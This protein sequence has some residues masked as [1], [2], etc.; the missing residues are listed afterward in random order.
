MANFG[1]LFWAALVLC[2]AVTF[3]SSDYYK[4]IVLKGGSSGGGG[5]D[6]SL[7]DEVKKVHAGLL[8]RYLFVYLTATLSDWLQGPYVY[9]LYSDYGFQ[10]HEIAQLFVAGF[11]SSMIF[12]SFVGGMADWGG[13]R[14]FV[15]LFA[16]VY[17]ASCITKHFKDYGVLMLGR[18]LGGVSTSLLFSIFEAWLIRAHA[19]ADLPKSC[20][21]KS[22]SWA[23]FG[24]SCVAITAG[25]VANNIAHAGPMTPVTDLIYKGGY[26][27]PFDLALVALVCCAVGAAVLWEENYGEESSGDQELTNGKGGRGKWYDG[28]KNAFTTTIRNREILLCGFISSFFEG[29][30]YIFVFMWT[31]LLRS[32]LEDPNG[33]LPF[34]LIFATF[35]VCCMT[36]SS[37]FS[38]LVEKYPV[39]KLAVGIFMVASVAMAIVAMEIN[40]TM[41]FLGMNIFEMTVGMYFPVMGTMKGGI[42]PEDK[43]AAIY[44]LYRIPLNFIVLFSL[45]TDLTPR[46]SFMLNATMLATATVLQAMLTKRRLETTGRQDTKSTDDVEQAIPLV[47]NKEESDH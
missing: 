28:L 4:K 32:F 17:A 11:G 13:R 47:S 43:R 31:P 39:E 1:A 14:F 27:N 38:I 45:L 7:S 20:L 33:D 22:F 37:I 34:G 40:E 35:M 6:Q 2:S 44:N 23:A 18:L 46:F 36:G 21:S 24:N 16:V 25:L 41:S 9:A 26:L 5:D 8:K 3:R 19:D 30:M 15:I 42:V 10:Q 29:S 12:G